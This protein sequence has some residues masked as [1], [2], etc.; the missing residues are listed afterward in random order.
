MEW[1]GLIENHSSVKIYIHLAMKREALLFFSDV[2]QLV[3]WT[4][5]CKQIQNHVPINIP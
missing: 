1:G 4:Y 3:M 2:K 5:S